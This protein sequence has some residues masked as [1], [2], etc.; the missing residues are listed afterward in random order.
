[1]LARHEGRIVLVSGAIPGER[2]SARLE[3]TERGVAFAEV[4]EV[5]QA[6]ADRR[7]AAGDARCG[8]NVFAHIAYPR[9]LALKGEIIQDAFRRIGRL[10]LPER[11]A[12]SPDR[13][14]M[15]IAC[16]RGCT[17]AEGGSASTSKAH[18][19]CATSA[20]T[21]QL[22]PETS[23]WIG[24]AQRM[25]ERKQL[26]G[27]DSDRDRREHPGRPARMPPGTSC[28]RRWRPTTQRSVGRARGA[29]CAARRSPGVVRIAGTPI[30]TD[31]IQVDDD[32]SHCA[33][34]QPGRESVL[35]R[36]QV[37]RRDNWSG[38]S[39]SSCRAG[40]VIDLYA[41]LDC[42][43]SS[44]AVAG[45]GVGDS[46][47]RRCRRRCGPAAQR[48]AVRRP[49]HGHSPQRRDLPRLGTARDDI[50]PRRSS[51]IRRAQ[52]SSKEAMAHLIRLQ[53]P[54]SSTSH[55]T[56][57]RWRATHVPCTTPATAWPTSAASTLPE[58]RARGNARALTRERQADAWSPAQLPALSSSVRERPRRFG[59]STADDA[60]QFLLGPQP[61]I[62]VMPMHETVL[63][64]ELVR[65]HGDLFVGDLW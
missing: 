15:D 29:V 28:R 5:L 52:A 1:M 56:S 61:V 63:F 19:R 4:A 23:Q 40:P 42:S 2:V 38:A 20:T 10:P 31:S 43:G 12:L 47:G 58:H 57:R 24:A 33:L 50:A 45:M 11:A 32:P 53:P 65:A 30:V 36:Q 51:S 27:V 60:L 6:S 54:A 59:R 3:R 62:D 49:R 37:S 26:R 14:S 22:L 25:L 41:A 55:A 21:G 8:G 7:P 35:S 48:G 16:A 34:A 13:P 44:L 46:R 9:Q 18:T 64:E 39:S 17:S